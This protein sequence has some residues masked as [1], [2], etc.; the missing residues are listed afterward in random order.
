MKYNVNFALCNAHLFECTSPC[1]ELDRE[2][3]N[4][5]RQEKKVIADI[6]KTAKTGQMVK[7]PIGV[8]I[9]VAEPFLHR[10]GLAK[11]EYYMNLW[12]VHYRST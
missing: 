7:L 9:W 10:V 5:E 8:V 2:R 6:K 3:A 1:R 4:L 12:D 11:Q